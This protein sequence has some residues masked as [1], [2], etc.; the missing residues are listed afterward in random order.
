MIRLNIFLPFFRKRKKTEPPQKPPGGF[1]APFLSDRE[2]G[3]K[4]LVR[5][6]LKGIGE[7]WLTSPWRRMVQ[8][9][10]FLLF[11]VLFVFVAWPYGGTNYAQ[12]RDSKEIIAAELF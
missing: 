11:V 8:A 5:R 7:T 9:T 12:F 3:R 4:G 1:W 2:T 6:I 10:F